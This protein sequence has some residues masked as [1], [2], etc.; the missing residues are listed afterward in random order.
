MNLPRG[1]LVVV[2]GA[3]DL[4]TG[5]I[6]RLVRSGF[7]VVALET[8]AP[9]AIR[10]TVALSEALYEGEAEVEG[11]RA[12][13]AARPEEAL[14]LASAGLVPILADPR[15][16]WLGI[17]S[18]L[19]LVDAILAK[20]NL[21]TRRGM[22]PIVVALGPGFAAPLDA[23]AVIETNRGHGLGRVI[24]SG[25]AEPDTGV[26]GTIAGKG[27]E[28]VVRA[29]AAG[30]VRALRE[31]GCLVEAGEPLLEIE[32]I[33]GGGSAVVPSPLRGVL[34]G[35]IRGGSQVPRGLKIADVDPR[36]EPAHCLSVSDKARAVAGGVLEAILSMG[37]RP[38]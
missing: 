28:R 21:G 33:A 20:R 26:P 2:R 7:R 24:L 3:G 31:I 1:G 10:R 6:V 12:R 15:C 8:A 4:A 5:S 30:T 23:H 37:G 19:A 13:S 16:A 25:S 18:P 34:R 14:A 36:C 17:L 11:V 29:P 32:G 9:T 35:M 22:A 27:A 38:E